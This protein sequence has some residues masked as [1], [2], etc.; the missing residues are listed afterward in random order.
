VRIIDAAEGSDEVALLQMIFRVGAVALGACVI[1]RHITD[2]QEGG[3]N[4]DKN[5]MTIAQ[6]KHMVEEVRALTAA[7]SGSGIKGPVSA[8]ERTMDE[9]S[10]RGTRRSLYAVRAIRADETLAEDML[11]TLRPMRGVEPKDIG[12]IIG[13][14]TSHDIQARQ[15]ITL[16]DVVTQGAD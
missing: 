9:M 2:S 5:S 6:F 14:K 12:R 7:L 4:D 16:Q 1:E 3:S 15:P 8:P 11:I 13:K 10:E